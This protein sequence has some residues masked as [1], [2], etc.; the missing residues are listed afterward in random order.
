MAVQQEIKDPFIWIKDNAIATDVCQQLIERFEKYKEHQEQGVTGGG[1]QLYIK[2]SFDLNI[3]NSLEFR[4]ITYI[5]NTVV[6]E[7][8]CNYYDHCKK[9]TR[10]S[11]MTG[12]DIPIVI[13]VAQYFNLSHQVQKTLPTKGYTWHTDAYVGRILTYIFYLNDVEEGW[14]EFLQGDKISPK[15]G[16]LLIFPSDSTYYHQGC[17]PKTDKYIST[18]WLTAFQTNQMNF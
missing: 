8:L 10:K 9:Q 1:L 5:L 18:G 2:D 15:E 3:S 17:P 4:D 7:E 12:E 13:P 11:F 16:R 14:T 6:Q